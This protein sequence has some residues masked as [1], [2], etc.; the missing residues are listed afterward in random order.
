MIPQLQRDQIELIRSEV[1]EMLDLAFDGLEEALEKTTTKEQLEPCVQF[2]FA[3][4][5]SQGM[6]VPFFMD[7]RLVGYLE[8]IEERIPIEETADDNDVQEPVRD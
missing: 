8:R 5:D 7:D 6:M 1:R 3:T 2:I 4:V